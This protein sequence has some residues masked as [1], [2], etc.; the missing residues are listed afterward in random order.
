MFWWSFASITE[1]M[2][3]KLQD[4]Y[5]PSLLKVLTDHSEP[6]KYKI[7]VESEKFEG[8]SHLQRHWE[9]N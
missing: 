8:M 5:K 3:K 1:I 6:D 2:E 9:I 7:V 4:F